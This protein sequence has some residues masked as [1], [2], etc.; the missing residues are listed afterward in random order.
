MVERGVDTDGENFDVLFIGFGCF[1]HKRTHLHLQSLVGFTGKPPPNTRKSIIGWLE[2]NMLKIKP[3]QK[4]K[5][6][7]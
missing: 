6:L 1:Q 2:F 5:M 7:W 3:T 4:G